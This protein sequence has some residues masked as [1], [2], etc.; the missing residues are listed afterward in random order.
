MVLK[1][2]NEKT[3]SSLSLLQFALFDLTYI[4]DKFN[5]EILTEKIKNDPSFV[6]VQ[7]VY[8]GLGMGLA[9]M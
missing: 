6:S 4:R 3:Q 8:K 2:G 9:L 7:W 1:K 5:Y